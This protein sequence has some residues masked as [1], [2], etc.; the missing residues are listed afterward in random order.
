MEV[1]QHA[2]RMGSHTQGEPR[3]GDDKTRRVVLRGGCGNRRENA[4]GGVVV[5]KIGEGD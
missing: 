5:A 1:K 3:E 2:R 4:M